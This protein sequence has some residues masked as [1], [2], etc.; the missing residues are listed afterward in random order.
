MKHERGQWSGSLGFV[1]AAAGSAVGLGNIWKFPG[2]AYAG[3]GASFILIYIAIVA[4][5]GATVMLAEFALGRSQHANAAES[6]GKIRRKWKWVGFLGVLAG[7]IISCYYIQV[8]GWVLN[9]VY[10]Y[11]VESAK[12]FADPLNYFYGVIGANGFPLFGAVIFPLLFLLISIF[13]L[14]KGTSGIEKFNKWA[15]P[16]LFLLLVVLMVRAVTL[17][18]AQ[19][20]IAYLLHIDWSKVSGDTF[21]M[22]LGQAFFSLSLG[23]AIMITYGSYLKK[24]ENLSRNVGIICT[25]DTVVALIA[26]FIIIP[27]V[28]AT[29]IEPGMGGGFAFASL[30]GVFENMPAGAFF[31][32]LFYVLLLVAAITSEISIFEGT[33][34]FVSEE[35]KMT[36][37]KTIWI[38]AVIMFLIGLLYTLSQA[39]LPLKGIWFDCIN[40]VQFPIFGDFMEYC[41]DRLIMPLAALFTCIFVG[42]I[43]KPQ[44]AIQEVEQGGKFRFHCAKIWT[45]L[46]KFI[47]PAAI[48]TIIV[49]SL[50]TGRTL[51]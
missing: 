45:V 26:G 51:S 48:L 30:A 2:K 19:E 34:A 1:L 16:L 10:A 41:T 28:F 14:L 31:G 39:Y 20:G 6:F 23:M 44:N 42:W 29:G 21:I 38:L 4:L 17:D 50:V 36:R 49:V 9:Y 37:K 12:V 47:A 15:M 18:G 24:E 33:I 13:V 43:W 8:G 7:F 32:V 35:F 40:G 25:F 22:A 3:G 46:V 5:I 27:A 11:I